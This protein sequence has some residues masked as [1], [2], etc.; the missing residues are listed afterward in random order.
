MEKIKSKDDQNNFH[1]TQDLPRLSY[2][3]EKFLKECNFF[4]ILIKANAN[5]VSIQY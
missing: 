2:F 4:Q 3:D 5:K 1:L